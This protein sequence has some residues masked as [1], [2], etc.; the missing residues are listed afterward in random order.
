MNG[1]SSDQRELHQFKDVVCSK[2]LS[3]DATVLIRKLISVYPEIDESTP[4]VSKIYINI[5]LS[6]PVY[7][8]VFLML[9]S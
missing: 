3:G 9:K 4:H 8:H 1:H 7:I 2:I 6:S 5:I